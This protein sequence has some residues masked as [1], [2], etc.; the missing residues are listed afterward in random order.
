MATEIEIKYVFPAN[1]S[2]LLGQYLTELG[3]SLGCHVLDNEYFDTPA[4]T[5]IQNRC[6][7]RIRR[8]YDASVRID[9]IQ[10]QQPIA[11]EQT[12]KTAGKEVAGVFQRQEW[13]WPIDHDAVVLNYNYLQQETIRQYLPTDLPLIQ[14]ENQLKPAFR[15]LFERQRWLIEWQGFRFEAA[16]DQGWVSA[17]DKKD[18]ISELELEWLDQG[19]ISEVESA[20][21][22]LG[23]K[24]S[25]Q[26]SLL[27][28]S[29]SKAEKGY[30]LVN[31]NNN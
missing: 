29:I 20:L 15:T 19:E 12:L 22:S 23:D 2:R 27:P 18:S 26:I 3:Q 9:D 7:L 14:L 6:A 28:S 17:K 24:L 21:R 10:Q 13:N 11:A 30:R 31:S 16:I 1:Q 25:Q 5:L 8:Q 4:Q